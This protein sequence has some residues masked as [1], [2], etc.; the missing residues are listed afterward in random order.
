MISAGS[1]DTVWFARP[2]T[3]GKIKTNE[4]TEEEAI[5]FNGRGGFP[6]RGEIDI[7]RAVPQGIPPDTF[8]YSGSKVR[9]L[10]ER[11]GIHYRDYCERQYRSVRH[12]FDGVL[13]WKKDV[14]KLMGAEARQLN[15]R[16]GYRFGFEHVGKD[17]PGWLEFANPQ[18]VREAV[19]E[20]HY[21]IKIEWTERDTLERKA[22][23]R[24]W[25]K[26]SQAIYAEHQASYA[27]QLGV[28]A[29][30]LEENHPQWSWLAAGFREVFNAIG[31]KGINDD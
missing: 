15:R 6:G 20:A 8:H 9:M 29:D 24:E 17:A 28:Y 14:A 26:K 27:R 21:A 1:G 13:V 3:C 23:N 16:N 5:P 25:D 31:K 30:W 10:C 19:S 12:K 22:A 18:A 7:W 2:T 11:S 4:A